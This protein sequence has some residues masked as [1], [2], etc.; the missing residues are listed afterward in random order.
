VVHAC[1]CSVLCEMFSVTH[2]MTDGWGKDSLHGLHAHLTSVLWISTCGD[3]YKPLCMQLLL[4]RKKHFIA[5]WMPVRLSATTS[6]SLHGRGGPWWDV[7]RR[8]LNLM[9]NIL[10]TYYKC[11]LSAAT[12]KLNISGQMLTWTFSPVLVCG[13]CGQSFFRTFQLHPIY[14]ILSTVSH[15]RITICECSRNQTVSWNH[16]ATDKIFNSDY[17]IGVST[18]NEIPRPWL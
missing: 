7:S 9:K 3:T 2:I 8:A 17:A 1:W 5:L 6:A 11:V 15:I 13:T 18:I 16:V 12:H 4:T 10:S 14:Y